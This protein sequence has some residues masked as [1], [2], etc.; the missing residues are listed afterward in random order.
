MAT[1]N[2]WKMTSN[3]ISETALPTTLR[4]T[5]AQAIVAF[6][7]NQFIEIDGRVQRICAGGFGIFGHGNAP[8][9]DADP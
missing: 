6:L 4:M 9:H 8:S 7:A 5:V 3:L 2:G 1:D